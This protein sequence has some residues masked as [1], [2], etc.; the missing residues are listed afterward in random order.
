MPGTTIAVIVDGTI[1]VLIIA[2][3]V[4][5]LALGKVDGQTAIALIGA[6]AAYAAGSTKSAIAL[7]VPAPAQAVT[8]PQA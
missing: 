3:S 8:P 2:S 4:V 6:G 1:G 7:R 5:L